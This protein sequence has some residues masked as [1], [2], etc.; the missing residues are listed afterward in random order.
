L[1]EMLTGKTFEPGTY[2]ANPR[3]VEVLKAHL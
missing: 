3:I 1:Y 2:P